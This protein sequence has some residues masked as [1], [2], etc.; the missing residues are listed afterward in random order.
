MS[1]KV[2]EN[3]VLYG[4][5]S[6][7]ILSNRKEL[8]FMRFSHFDKDLIRVSITYTIVCEYCYK[9]FEPVVSYLF[10]IYGPMHGLVY[11]LIC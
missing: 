9:F 1:L 7:N 3:L 4:K 11:Q 8:L 2:T 6:N 5:R 10:S